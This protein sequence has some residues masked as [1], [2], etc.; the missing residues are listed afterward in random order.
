M[1]CFR[2][3]HA[4]CVAVATTLAGSAIPLLAQT[5]TLELESARTPSSPAFALL[6]LAPSA[7]ERPATPRA[8]AAEI[9]T[10]ADALGAFP[11]DYGL[12]FAPYWLVSHP[13]LEFDSFREPAGQSYL[14]TLTLSVATLRGTASEGS[15]EPDTT[16]MAFGVRS[17]LWQGRMSSRADSIVDRLDT[18]QDQRLDLLEEL[19]FL[20]PDSEAERI[21]LDTLLA[22]SADSLQTVATALQSAVQ[23]RVGFVVELAAALAVRYP[24]DAFDQGNRDR[25]GAWATVAYQLERPRVD[26][27]GVWRYLRLSAE[28]DEWARDAGLRAIANFDNFDISFELV[29]RSATDRDPSVPQPDPTVTSG[30]FTDFSTTRVTGS[31]EY[32]LSEAAGL[33]FTF[34]RDHAAD[35]GSG[36]PLVSHLGVRINIGDLP[37]IALPGSN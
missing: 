9:A 4:L 23:R 37:N 3:T 18:L 28:S 32:R 17:V 6:G 33:F 36:Q 7:I 29:R 16:T 10:R 24:G 8:L 22:A 2:I 1:R 25:W 5:D 35:P 30:T 34:G 15:S 12:E 26:V 13:T 31:I 19:A 20:E 14:R 27:L 21:R 11:N